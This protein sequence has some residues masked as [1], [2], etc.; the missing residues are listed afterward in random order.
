MTGEGRRKMA[1]SAADLIKNINGSHSYL[2]GII[3]QR[4][5]S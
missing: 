3:K 2:T 1:S 5:I 4:G